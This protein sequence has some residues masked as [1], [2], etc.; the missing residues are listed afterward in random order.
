MRTSF[1]NLTRAGFCLALIL[2]GA[3]PVNSFAQEKGASIMTRLYSPSRVE[4]RDTVAPV[5]VGP[6]NTFAQEKGATILMMRQ[7]NSPS[8]PEVQIAPLK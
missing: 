5:K 8:Q 2:V 6:V 3:A 4:N 1:I 7:R